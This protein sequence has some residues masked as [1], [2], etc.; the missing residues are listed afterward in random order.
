MTGEAV[1]RN[2]TCGTFGTVVI[3]LAD[4]SVAKVQGVVFI[5]VC[6]NSPASGDV[7]EALNG[8]SGDECPFAACRRRKKEN[9]DINIGTFLCVN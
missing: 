1:P 6:L 8:H 4:H 5:C 9:E 2:T 7:P 3:V